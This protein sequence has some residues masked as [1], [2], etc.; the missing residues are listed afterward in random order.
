[1]KDSAQHRK[2]TPNLRFRPATA[3]LAMVIV[4]ALMVATTQSAQAQTFQVIHNFTSGQ[5]GASPFAGLTMDKAGNLYGTAA[6]GGIGYGTIYELKRKGSGWVFNLL[7]SLNGASDGGYPTAGV[8]FGPDS[9]LYGTTTLNTLGGHGT[10]LKLKPSPSACVTAMCPWVATVLYTFKGSADGEVPGY[11]DLI[12]DQAGNVYGT[13]QVGGSGG[14]GIVYMLTPSSNG[15]WTKTVLHD[16]T[17]YPD[18]AVPLGGMIF[19]NAGNLY[20]TTQYGGS[21][22]SG[23]VFQLTY[24]SG[25]GWIENIIDNFQNGSDGGNPVA[26][27][28]SDQAGNLYGTTTNAGQSGGGTVFVLSPS[29]GGWTYTALYSFTG[30]KGNECGPWGT[31]TPDGAGNLYGTTRC[32]GANKAGSVFKLTSS[33]GGWTS[34]SL[35]DFTGGSDGGNPYGNVVLDAS[36][37]LYGTASTGGSLGNGVVWEITP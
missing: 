15:P 11:G 32:D 20:S 7:H 21:A 6:R 5:D 24:S 28:I 12:F 16:F 36:G 25:S 30:V 1:M 18:G 19:D 22:N 9:A 13:T 14:E 3:A 17:G 8:I 4:F 31:L 29:G 35:H 10:V 33:G 27:L 34:T 23:T 2:R 37:N 26:G